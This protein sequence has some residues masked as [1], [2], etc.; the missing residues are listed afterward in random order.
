[1]DWRQLRQRRVLAMRRAAYRR[2]PK[3][4]WSKIAWLSPWKMALVVLVAGTLMTVVTAVGV[5]AW[6]SRD[7]PTP[8]EVVRR[9]GFAT[10]IYD[11][12]DQLLYEFFQEQQRTPVKI[13]TVPPSLK[14]ATIAIEDKHFYA[15]QGFDPLGIARSVYIIFTRGEVVG[16]STLTQ[17]LVKN[18]L[19]SQEKTLTR[20]VKELILAV[21]IESLYNKEEI[22]QMYLNEAPY[23][24]TAWGV[25]TAAQTYFGKEVQDLNLVESAIL[26]GMPQRPT[27]YSPFGNYPDAYKGRTIDVLRRMR[28]DGYITADEE[29]SAAAALN[30][31]SFKGDYTAIKAPHFVFY[32]KE[33]L[34][35]MYGESLVEKGG[36]RVKTTLDLP[37]QEAAQTVVT[38]EIGKVVN[39]GI[40]N[41]SALVLNP[42]GGEIL[43]MV[44]SKDFFAEDYDGQV[45]VTEALRQPGSAIKPVTYAAAFQKGFTPASVIF[46]TPTEFPSG[47]VKP[48]AP[49]NYDGSFRGP[50]QLRFALGSSLNMPAV[51]L[52]AMVGLKD[53]MQLGYD[54]GLTTLEP[55]TENLKRFGLALTLGGGEVRLIDLATAYSTFA[56]GGL[57]VEPIAILKVTDRE[58]KTLYE[59]KPVQRKRILDEGVTYLVNHILSDNNARL[60]TFGANSYLKMGDNVAVKTG[61]TNDKRDNWTIGWNRNAVVGVWVGN[62]DNSPMKQVAS[63]VTGASP[64]WRRIMVEVQKNRKPEAWPIPS[65]V[66]AIQVDQVSGYPEHDG[67]PTRSE[68]IIKGTL[69][70]LP[71]PVHSK[72]KLCRGQERLA[73]P[74]QVARNDYEEKEYIVPNEPMKL[75]DLPSWNEQIKVWASAQGDPRLHPPDTMCEG[76]EA[77]AVDVEEPKNE[78]NYPDKEIRV[79]VRVI[80]GGTVERVDI[81]VNEVLRESLVERPYET[82]FS[83][84][85]GAYTVKVRARQTDGRMAESGGIQI[86]VGSVPWQGL[87]AA[88]PEP[89]PTGLSE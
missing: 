11:R 3:R 14:E 74:V 45:N 10:K 77:M 52:L 73:T 80:T 70:S 44:G 28:E 71:D 36:L 86:G 31:L 53:M 76:S 1:M 56:N 20:K 67:F 40:G 22:L 43:A 42:K 4:W 82:A 39:Q 62:N 27:V 49:V 85:D 19:L 50:V 79:K 13:E 66:A 35:E 23:G 51:K 7:L 78:T 32:V 24:G 37:L 72:L 2:G 25:G 16:G 21:Q 83:L 29:A 88:T 8:D 6:F 87:A 58:G 75:G 63:G 48:Y 17:Q 33:R 47:E 68:Y 60:L 38:E 59:P 89:S 69:P 65:N 46:D 54:M 18:V 9:E 15:H 34:E 84:P 26:A 81:Y 30:D 12:N 64:I 41:G 57:Q 5:F 55:T 61:T